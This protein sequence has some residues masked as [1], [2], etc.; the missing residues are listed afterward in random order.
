MLGT[1]FSPYKAPS[2]A[3]LGKENDML[4]LSYSFAIE[5]WHGCWPC[6]V[7]HLSKFK[8]VICST[9]FWYFCWLRTKE[10]ILSQD[11]AFEK[12]SIF[13]TIF[14]HVLPNPLLSGLTL[15]EWYFKVILHVTCTFFFKSTFLF[16]DNTKHLPLFIFR[17]LGIWNLAYEQVFFEPWSD[18]I[19]GV[20]NVILVY[21]IKHLAWQLILKCNISFE[22]RG[23][24]EKT[25]LL[26]IFCSD[27]WKAAF[28]H[29]Q[30]KN[31]E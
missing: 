29:W 4:R 1:P 20:Q 25:I 19:Y 31:T 13:L 15:G 2:T 8:A 21:V 24:W 10:L 28:K 27:S 14:F 18:F 26:C 23:H 5:V 9:L 17:K 3:R 30:S 11:Y 7:V 22:T 12:K 6:M 16:K